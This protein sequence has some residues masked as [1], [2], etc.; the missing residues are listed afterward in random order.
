[1]RARLADVLAESKF[2]WRSLAG[3]RMNLIF[4]SHSIDFQLIF[5]YF[6]LF[7]SS[8]C[9]FFSLGLPFDVLADS[10]L[11]FISASLTPSSSP[12]RASLACEEER[13]TSRH[14]YPFRLPC[15]PPSRTDAPGFA[16]TS[17]GSS[18]SCSLS[19]APCDRRERASEMVKSAVE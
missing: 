3:T 13:K 2:P 4:T 6:A 10:C 16:S 15:L 19:D 7:S 5:T 8:V 17:K 9:R 1:M 14:K 12:L 11:T 18:L